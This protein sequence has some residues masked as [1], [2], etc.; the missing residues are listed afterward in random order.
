MKKLI[1]LGVVA[2]AAVYANAAAVAWKYTGVA[3]QVDYTVYAFTSAVADQYDTFAD[4]IENASPYSGT[5]NAVSGRT[6]TTYYTNPTTL[7]GVSDTM[8]LVVVSGSDATEYKYGSVST[9]GYTYD[10]DAQETAPDTL[11]IPVSSIT[12][13]GKIGAVPEPTS[14]LLMLVG[15]AGLALRRRRA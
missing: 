2:L 14:G 15:L 8:Y 13:I 11:N 3:D 4:L 6:G 1:T 10:P 12:S 5:V 7:T 9:A